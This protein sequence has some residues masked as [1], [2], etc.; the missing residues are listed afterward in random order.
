M[1][2]IYVHRTPV[3]QVR[4][5]RLQIGMTVDRYKLIR[6]NENDCIVCD[7]LRPDIT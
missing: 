3:V 5:P 6:V 7:G 1:I 2:Y 4:S